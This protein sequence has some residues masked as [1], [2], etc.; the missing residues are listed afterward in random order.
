MFVGSY[1][2]EDGFFITVL[3]KS[4]YISGA[5]GGRGGEANLRHQNG[6]QRKRLH[7]C[8]DGVHSSRTTIYRVWTLT[9]LNNTKR[10]YQ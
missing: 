6:E 9:F 10:F 7:Q 8:F 5:T 1:E 2:T 3:R 4:S